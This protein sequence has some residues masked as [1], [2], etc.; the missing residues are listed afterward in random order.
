M[1]SI[2][3]APRSTFPGRGMGVALARRQKVFTAVRYP[4]WSARSM[5]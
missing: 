5:V 2:A 1:I 3:G 4:V